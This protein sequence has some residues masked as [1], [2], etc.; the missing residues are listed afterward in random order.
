MKCPR[1]QS[2]EHSKNGFHQSQQ[3]YICKKCGRQWI[4]EQRSRGY[5]QP[6]RDLC[7]T[8]HRNGLDAK[9]IG[10]YTGISYNTIIN[11]VNQA[12]RDRKGAIHPS[13]QSET[14]E[15]E[16]GPDFIPLLNRADRPNRPLAR[17]ICAP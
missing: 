15:E 6:V 10:Q 17:S 16:Y 13:G 9:V 11:W 5:P 14:L 7:L 1:C 3:K 12:R 8:M 4:S 2:T